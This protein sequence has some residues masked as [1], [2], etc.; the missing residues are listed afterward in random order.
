MHVHDSSRANQFRWLTLVVSVLVLLACTS[1]AAHVD[2]ARGDDGKGHCSICLAATS[3]IVQ[4]TAAVQLAPQIVAA[5]FT[6]DPDPLTKQD[7]LP[8]A[9]YI[10]PP[11]SC[12][13]PAVGASA[14]YCKGQVWA[15]SHTKQGMSQP[16]NCGRF[17]GRT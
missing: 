7:R 11:P 15:F 12:Y 17:R 6:P 10:R 4:P 2:K 14:V 8:S 16:L 1:F 3:H 9:L 13:P 5:A